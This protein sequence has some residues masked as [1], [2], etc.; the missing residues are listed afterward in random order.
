MQPLS[1]GA[2]C[3]KRNG[4]IHHKI[5]SRQLMKTLIRK[6]S[7]RAIFVVLVLKIEKFLFEYSILSFSGHMNATV[8]CVRFC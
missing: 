8:L 2:G 1:V 3:D 6:S 7:M 5:R 4:L